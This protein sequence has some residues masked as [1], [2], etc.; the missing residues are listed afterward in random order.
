[1]LIGS[2]APIRSLCAPRSPESADERALVF[3]YFSLSH[4]RH[5]SNL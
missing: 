5:E 2:G 1:M 4:E 3:A